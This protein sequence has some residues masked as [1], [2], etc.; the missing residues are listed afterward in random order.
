M[1]I[2]NSSPRPHSNIVFMGTLVRGGHGIGVVYA[3]GNNTNLGSVMK[4]VAEVSDH[5]KGGLKP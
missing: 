2:T 4:M 5:R 1:S 3:I